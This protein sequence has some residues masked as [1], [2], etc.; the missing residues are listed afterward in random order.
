[1]LVNKMFKKEKPDLRLSE[2]KEKLFWKAYF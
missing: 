1:M 2:K